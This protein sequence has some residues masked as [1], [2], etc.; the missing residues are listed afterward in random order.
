MGY[1]ALLLASLTF[2][3]NPPLYE[4]AYPNS[5]NAHRGDDRDVRLESADSHAE[6]AIRVVTVAE[7]KQLEEMEFGSDHASTG[8]CRADGRKVRCV[9]YDDRRGEN[10][11]LTVSRDSTVLAVFATVRTDDPNLRKLVLEIVAS[12]RIRK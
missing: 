8:T 4:V 3:A 9:R 10:T 2:V 5:W 7:A 1:I 11:F 12:I 6:V